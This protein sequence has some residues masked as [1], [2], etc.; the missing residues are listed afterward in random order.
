MNLDNVNSYENL[1]GIQK[2]FVKIGQKIKGK[3]T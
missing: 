1:S 3:F 2:F